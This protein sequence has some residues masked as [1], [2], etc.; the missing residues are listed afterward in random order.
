[1]FLWK[2]KNVI[3]FFIE[4][5]ALLSGAMIMYLFIFSGQSILK[6]NSTPQKI[7]PTCCII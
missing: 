4:K 7:V 5:R 3:T 1:M 2:N 6:N